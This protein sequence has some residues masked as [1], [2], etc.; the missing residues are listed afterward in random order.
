MAFRR[1]CMGMGELWRSY[2]KRTVVRS[3]QSFLPAIRAKD[4]G[5]IPVGVRAQLV[6]HDGSLAD[7][8]VTRENE[9]VLSVGNTPSPAATASFNVCR[10]IFGRLAAR[11][12]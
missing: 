8:V 2:N 7:E 6:A 3:P 5:A 1:S 10:R 11:L 4:L 9:R 12:T